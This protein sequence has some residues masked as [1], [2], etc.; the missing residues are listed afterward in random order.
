[1]QGEP[2]PKAPEARARMDYPFGGA[3]L[4]CPFSKLTVLVPAVQTETT[5][6]HA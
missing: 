2:A 1:M 4:D 3:W 6:I 5:A